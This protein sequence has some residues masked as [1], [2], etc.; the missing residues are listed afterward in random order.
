MLAPNINKGRKDDL[1][2]KENK[3]KHLTEEAKNPFG[4]LQ[5]TTSKKKETTQT[6]T[7]KTT[8]TSNKPGMLSLQMFASSHIYIQN[9]KAM[10]NYPKVA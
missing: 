8:T 9:K 1:N 5:P 2:L 4:R 3:N 7:T 6:A 10:P